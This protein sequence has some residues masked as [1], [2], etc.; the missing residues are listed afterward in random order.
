MGKRINVA[1]LKKDWDNMTVAEL[2]KKYG[3]S[4]PTLRK[5]LAC[6]DEYYVIN[7]RAV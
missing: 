1:Q 2:T 3:A 7:E 5:A 6:K 4:D